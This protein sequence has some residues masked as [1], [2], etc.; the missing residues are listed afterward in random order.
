MAQRLGD[1]GYEREI[2]I[3]S[4]NSTNQQGE[5]K[6]CKSDEQF[7]PL[8]SAPA[9]S[10]ADMAWPSGINPVTLPKEAK[11]NKV[12]AEGGSASLIGGASP[13]VEVTDGSVSVSGAKV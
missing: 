13:P 5:L 7:P 11:D 1:G 9:R 10:A 3:S 6:F 2:V 8:S 4:T 12:K